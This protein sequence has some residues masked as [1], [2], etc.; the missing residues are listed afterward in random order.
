MRPIN[1]T[2]SP[3]QQ[4]ILGSLTLGGYDTSRF[5][6]TNTSFPLAG[7][8]SESLAIRIESIAASKTLVSNI[9]LLSNGIV[10]LIDT[11]LPYFS[12]PLQ[13]CRQFESAFGLSWDPSTDMYLVNDTIHQQLQNLNPSVTFTLGNSS[14]NQSINI[15]LPY[16]AFD[17]QASSPIYPNGTNYFPLHQAS[18]ASEYVLGRAFLQEAYLLVDFE[19]GN[20]SVS[21][22][23]FP[24]NPIP[25]IITIDHSSRPSIPGTNVTQPS[26]T[27]TRH[28]HLS[29]GAIAGIAIGASILLIL[30]CTI[31]FFLFFRRHRHHDGQ[32]SRTPPSADPSS[33]P[34]L[35]DKESWPTSPGQ[36]SD[37]DTSTNS[38]ATTIPQVRELEDTQAP[39]K[40]GSRSRQELAGSPTAKELPPL[41]SSESGKARHISELAGDGLWNW[42]GKK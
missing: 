4:P 42:K 10:A 18:T 5:L 3:D 8:D 41:P 14:A 16:G 27:Q 23:L 21:Q 12:L 6:Q 25:N 1:L 17:L 31:A 30:L 11:T 19:K 9:T 7:N 26:A 32:T 36:F 22:A 35:G 34:P 24:A 28:H 38:N 29:A 33:P 39:R 20:F 2:L 37:T 15:T 13:V 40:A